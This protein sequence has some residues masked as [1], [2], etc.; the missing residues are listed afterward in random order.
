[1]R[2]MNPLPE[3]V[4]SSVRSGIIL[5]D[6]TRVVEELVFNSLDAGATKVSVYVGVGT[7]FV[8]VVDDGSGVTR[9]GLVLLGERYATSKFHQL[10]DMDAAGGSFGFRG[11]AL[12][13]ISDVSLLEI[14]TKAYGRPNGYRKVI[15]GCKC[16]YLGIDNDRKDVGTTVNVRDLFYNQPVRRKYMQSSP[17]K[18]LH[19]VKKGVL[20]IALVHSQVYFKVIDIESGDELLCTQPSSPL[21]LLKSGFGLEVSD[22]LHKLNISDGVLKLSGYISDPVDGFE[23]KAFQYVYI[24]SRFVCKGPIHKLLNQLATS[25]ECLDPW[26]VNNGSQNRK[27]SRSQAYPAYILNLSC[28]RSLYDLT[29]EPSKTYVEFKDWAPILTFTEKAIQQLWKENITFGDSINHVT[30]II[31][32]DRIWKEADDSL[33]AEED[34]LDA[35]L[36]ETSEIVK[37]K[38]RIKNHK[39]SLDIFSS[40]S[41]M[42]TKE[43]D[44]LSHAGKDRIPFVNLH[45]NSAE[46]K[47]QQI[48]V[49]FVCQT[50]Y[51]FQ[52]WDGLEAKCVPTATCKFDN[53]LLASD[54]N[55]LSME[56]HFLENRANDNVDNCLTSAWGIESLKDDPDVINESAGVA[57]SCDLIG[58]GI[59]KPLLQGCSSRRSLPLER[60]LFVNDEGFEFQRDCFRN[61][62]Q[63]AGINRYKR[64]R[65]LMRKQECEPDHVSKE[66]SRRSR[67]A[68]PFYRGKRK[69]FSWNHPSIMKAG[70]PKAKTFHNTLTYSEVNGL[71]CAKQ[72][73]DDC[74]LY[75]MPSTVEHLLSDT[76]SDMDK[77]IGISANLKA[78]E[79]GEKFE[80]SHYFNCQ[81]TAPV[82]GET[83]DSMN[84]WSKWRNCSSQ[85]TD[86]NKSYDVRD[87]S[88]ILDISSGFLHLAGDLLVPE[89][90][91]TSCLVDAKVLQ[92]VDKKF[93]PVVGD[94][95]LAVI[96]QHAAD[97]RIR[98]EE[99]R[100][101]V[102][103]GEAKTINYLD[104]EQEL[105]LPEIAYQLL[106][107]YAEEIKDWGWICNIHGEDSRSF[108][109]N[110]NL[111]HK[112]PTVITLV[113][114]PNILGVNL[115]DVDLLE[116]LQQ[117]A[118]TDGSSTIPPSVL[119]V[120]NMKACRGAIMFGDSLLP[121]ECSLIVEELKQTSL[122]FQCAHGRPT[123]IPLVNLEALHKQIAKL[124]LLDD[125]SNKLWRGLRRHELSF[126]RATERLSSARG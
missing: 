79:E 45:K 34:F 122:C 3:A 12:A 48:Q 66:R 29:F 6:L 76:R 71:K 50:D 27:R 91:N 65:D 47:E 35:D 44:H 87:D 15:K 51:A 2:S 121:S 17:K 90:I 20:R 53:Q 26:K 75:H 46:V 68:P 69:F 9:D 100:K 113:A 104:S 97:E 41:D 99:L 124:G 94:G 126:Q 59:K 77:T 110:L 83:L 16:L 85:L 102:L 40:P 80:Q 52:S 23:I 95:T 78:I 72:P 98:L 123:T 118:D 119:R 7:C 24:N 86:R 1:M 89:S 49:G 10:A 109:R 64:Q 18:V 8:K 32:K 54:N 25:F 115:S 84:S 112:R 39:A 114:V 21:L 33:T 111:L 62:W 14:T 70:K 88:S 58:R 55:F 67:S 60:A 106:Q 38:R 36:S 19:S 11:E 125:N 108:K 31:R 93:I 61:D 4:R 30:D 117:L 96:D 22:S 120:L 13:S 43:V 56:D 28:P 92:Q 103:S 82:K 116:F 63:Q 101:K 107:N 105:M 81:D 73:S 5:F 42:L 74:H 57:L 37:K